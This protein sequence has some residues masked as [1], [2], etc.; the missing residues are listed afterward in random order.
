MEA[1]LAV[2]LV[3]NSSILKDKNAEVGIYVGDDNSCAIKKVREYSEPEVVKLSDVNHTSKGVTKHM[4]L[5]QKR[6]K[7]LTKDTIDYLHKCFT[8]AVAQNKAHVD[9]MAHAIRQIPKHAFNDHDGCGIWC[10]YK[11][12]EKNY[13]HQTIVGGFQ[14]SSLLKDLTELFEKLADNCAKFAHGKSSQ[15][16]E[17]VNQIMASKCLKSR[18]YS[19]RESADF[20]FASAIATK[21]LGD[22]YIDRVTEKMNLSSNTQNF[23]AH[24]KRKQ[25]IC[26]KRKIYIK[27]K[28]FKSQRNLLKKT[29]LL[30][31]TEQNM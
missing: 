26:E 5:L 22:A 31:D 19:T 6:H 8:Y 11:G 15:L 16:N 10:R 1:D 18:C 30:S 28:K 23:Y 2:Q 12:N 24:L 17:N 21:N 7:E 29:E 13:E 27:S 25:K 9:E 14:S 20:R 4:F 3:T